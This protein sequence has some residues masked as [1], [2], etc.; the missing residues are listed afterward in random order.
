MGRQPAAAL[1]AGYAVG[2]KN[3]LDAGWRAALY[4]MHPRVIAW[5]VLP[6]ALCASVTALLAHAY[7]ASA[8]DA[9]S[10]A[11]QSWSFSQTLLHW[12]DVSG[13]GGL[14]AMVAPLVVVALA[15]PVLVV[16]SLLV[17][18]ALMSP[19]LVR[20][21]VARR[22]PQLQARGTGGWLINAARSFAWTVLGLLVLVLSLP[23]WLIPPLAIVLPPLIWGWLTERVMCDEVLAQHASRDE[24]RDL[25]RRHRGPLLLMGV[26]TGYLGAAPSMLWAMGA[27]TLAFAP[28]LL[29]FSM[30]LYTLIFAFSALWFAHYALAALD[31]LRG[32][33]EASAAPGAA[34]AVSIDQMPT[35]DRALGEF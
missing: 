28:L 33:G 29:I 11:L 10:Q 3:V 2:M 7:W 15:V 1:Q 12:L 13:L 8:T 23:L 21:V 26:I 27:L 31:E 30:W 24:R 32:G 20:L 16:F 6:L 34:P 25:M 4:C 18:A 14:R 35:H 17:V 5:S 9:V 22:F 19:A